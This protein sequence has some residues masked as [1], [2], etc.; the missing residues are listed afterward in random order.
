[1]IYLKAPIGSDDFVS[2]WL[3]EKLSK[4]EDIVKAVALMPFKHEAFTLLKSCAAECRVM[5]LMRVV[6]PHQ[7][8]SFMVD[9]DKVLHEGFE[10][11]LGITI[12]EKWW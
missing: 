8:R 12:E 5:Y 7:L 11:L 9:F 1:M 3:K 10:G 2:Q 6:P 4:L